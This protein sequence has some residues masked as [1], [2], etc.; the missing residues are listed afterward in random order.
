[1]SI[2]VRF[3]QSHGNLLDTSSNAPSDQGF[4]ALVQ[5]LR[6]DPAFELLDAI[7]DE[8]SLE[9]QLPP[10]SGKVFVLA[11]PTRPLSGDEIQIIWR[12]VKTGGGLLLLNNGKAWE[13]QVFS[14]NALAARCGCR[15]GFHAANSPSTLRCFAPHYISANLH[16]PGVTL[17]ENPSLSR[18][19]LVEGEAKLESLAENGYNCFLATGSFQAGRIVVAGNTAMFSNQHLTHEGNQL[20]A[21]N[22]FSWLAKT[23]PVDVVY[24][25]SSESVVFGEHCIIEM[26]LR[27]VTEKLIT[28]TK[29]TLESSVNDVISE[30]IIENVRL[31]PDRDGTALRRLRWQV[32]PADV[33]GPRSL[34]LHHYLDDGKTLSWQFKACTVVLPEP[35]SLTTMSG[36]RKATESVYVGQTFNIEAIG[37]T[38][39]W[40]GQSLALT[41]EL[42]FS[43]QHFVLESASWPAVLRWRLTARSPGNHPVALRVKETG[44]LVCSGVITV[45]ESEATQ[46]GAIQRTLVAPLDDEIRRVLKDLSPVLADHTLAQIP[47]R[48]MSL[49]EYIPIAFPFGPAAQ[50]VRDVVEAGYWDERENERVVADLLYNLEPTYSPSK[51]AFI[52]FAPSLIDRLLAAGTARKRELLINFLKGDAVTDLDMCRQIAAYL[53]H[54]KYG[55]GFFYT[56]TQ[57]GRQLAVLDKH[58]FLDKYAERILAGPFPQ[59]LYR[60]YSRAIRL[61][62]HSALIMNEGVAAWIELNVLRRLRPELHAIIPER[63][64][65]MREAK[66]LQDVQRHSEY[67]RK[68]PLGSQVT[69]PYE[70]GRHRLDAIQSLY[71]E[72]FGSKCA[73]QAFIVATAIPLGI[74][75][76][77]DAPSFGLTADALA[78]ALLD[79]NSTEARSDDRLWRISRVLETFRDQVRMVQ[80]HL[81]CSESCLHPE[82]PVRAQIAD[83]LGWRSHDDHQDGNFSC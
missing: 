9:E 13:E 81:H 15:F 8:T 39:Q 47:F 24:A 36:E 62:Q 6:E 32:Q 55:H 19:S 21:R 45:Q 38:P 40:L 71:P 57:L 5:I 2:Q 41:P 77:R 50:L 12:F 43:H 33:L 22:V 82:C 53:S 16:Q 79:E 70:E 37:T 68:F 65:F 14:L 69:S 18:V 73:I 34:Y 42:Q 46:I 83:K 58:R 80:D 3:D 7:K 11:A 28:I 52:P 61:I 10:G 66:T 74:S 27:N 29:L 76:G 54:E 67:F 63:E 59:T 25:H 31:Y 26:G 64:V 72:E 56:Y 30:P 1:M 60:E 20:L 17:G 35:F 4:S 51:G 23:N 78:Q 44:Q 48:L 49:D 75:D